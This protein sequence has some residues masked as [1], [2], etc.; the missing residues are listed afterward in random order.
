MHIKVSKPEKKSANDH[1]IIH[2][3]RVVHGTC[4]VLAVPICTAQ[5]FFRLYRYHFDMAEILLV[6]YKVH[7]YKLVLC[8]RRFDLFVGPG[9]RCL[10]MENECSALA[11]APSP[12]AEPTTRIMSTSA[13]VLK[14]IQMQ[15]NS[16]LLLVYVV[17]LLRPIARALFSAIEAK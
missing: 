3:P 4:T 9:P 10:R 17:V 12:L 5:M 14:P 16:I 8:A 6:I 7:S 2:A 1:T 11:A 13:A 15:C